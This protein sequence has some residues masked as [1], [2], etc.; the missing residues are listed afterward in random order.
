MVLTTFIHDANIAARRR[1]LI[2]YHPI[3]IAQL[4]GG[5]VS[6]VAETNRKFSQNW[7][8]TS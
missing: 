5:F 7:M 6:L 1:L 8:I 4:L 3:E 2:W